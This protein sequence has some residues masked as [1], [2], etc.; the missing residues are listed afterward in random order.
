MLH[1]ELNNEGLADHILKVHNTSIN[2]DTNINEYN[3]QEELNRPR[4]VYRPQKKNVRSKPYSKTKPDLQQSSNQSDL[5]AEFNNLETQTQTLNKSVKNNK[6][7]LHRNKLMNK[8]KQKRSI[9]PY[10]ENKQ[11][12]TKKKNT[13]EI[14]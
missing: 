7:P 12:S 11:N 6:L 10:P 2:Q 13:N 1:E 5:I 8:Y 3:S 9:R 14:K 4:L